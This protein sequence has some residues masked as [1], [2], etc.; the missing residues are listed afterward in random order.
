MCFALCTAALLAAAARCAAHSRAEVTPCYFVI[1]A[2][3]TSKQSFSKPNYTHIPRCEQPRPALPTVFIDGEA[4]TTGLQV[5]ALEL[6]Y[7]Q[8]LTCLCCAAVQVRE[9][10]LSRTDLRVVSLP[11]AQRK[12]AR[13]R[14]DALNAADAAILCL[15]DD[16]AVEAAAMLEP[17][18]TRTVL[19]DASTAFRTADGWTYG[20]P[21]LTPAGRYHLRLE[22]R[23]SQ[24]EREREEGSYSAAGPEILCVEIAFDVVRPAS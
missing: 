7:A 11:D 22:A 18:N 21:E 19:I 10:L 1:G 2:L 8:P 15:P 4:G 5:C 24:P 6:L 20:F 17:S 3:L 16:A 9:R 23:E 14:A 13:A 12:D